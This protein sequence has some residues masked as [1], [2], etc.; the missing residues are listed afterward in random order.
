MAPKP[1]DACALQEKQMARPRIKNPRDCQLNL[2]LTVEELESIRCRAEA[3]GMR[4]VHFGRA[5]ILDPD[6]KVAVAPPRENNLDRLVYGQLARLGSNLNQLVKYLH[7]T[8]DPLPPDL[9]PLLADI[10]AIIDRRYRDDH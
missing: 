6:R 2:S 9:E 10:R 8:G 3:V 4:P 1:Q 7:I 5:L